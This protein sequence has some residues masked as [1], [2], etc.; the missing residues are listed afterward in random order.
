HNVPS[1]YPPMAQAVYL[2]SYLI[3]P[4][5]MLVLKAIFLGFDLVTCCMLAF[6]LKRKGLDPA[7]CLIYAWCPLPLVEFAIQ[8][9]IDAV[10]LAFLMLIVVCAM[11]TRRGMRLLRGFLLGLATLT[12]LYPIIL[13]V[14]VMRRRDYALLLTCLL[15]ILAGYVPYLILG[16][17]HVL[18]FFSTYINQHGGNGGFVMLALLWIGKLVGLQPK[19][20][21]SF[22]HGIDLLILCGIA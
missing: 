16:H 21:S 8:G 9:H 3:A 5:N 20:L 1:L 14:V 11:S 10:M 22:E 15:T 7:R 6:L 17:G 2:L 12:K 19:A 18:G 13:L 4:S